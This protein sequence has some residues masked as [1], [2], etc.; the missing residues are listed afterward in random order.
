MKYTFINLFCH[1][2]AY[3]NNENHQKELILLMKHHL[4]IM[5]FIKIYLYLFLKYFN[6]I[7]Y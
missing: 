6:L 3:M 1:K 5:I 4:D 7:Y 2:K